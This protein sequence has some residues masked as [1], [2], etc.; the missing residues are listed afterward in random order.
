MTSADSTDIDEELEYLPADGLTAPFRV[1]G[2]LADDAVN[3]DREKKVGCLFY[4]CFVF[5]TMGGD[6]DFGS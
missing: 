3:R 2:A 5:R 1:L 4:F 6:A